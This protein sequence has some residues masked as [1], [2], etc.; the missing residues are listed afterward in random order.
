[1]SIMITII[2]NSYVGFNR[3]RHHF[4]DGFIG[5]DLISMIRLKLWIFFIGL[6]TVLLSF[7]TS[8]AG[9]RFLYLIVL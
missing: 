8:S 4:V 2:F 1:M 6:T 3:S 5:F 7:F 9:L